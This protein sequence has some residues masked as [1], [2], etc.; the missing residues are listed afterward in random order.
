MVKGKMGLP[1]NRVRWLS[2]EQI[3]KYW[4]DEVGCDPKIIQQELQLAL[5]NLPRLAAGEQLLK[6]HPP[7][8]HLPAV[9]TPFSR[10]DILRFC[11]KQG[12]PI[13]EFWFGRPIRE[14]GYAGRPAKRK[15]AIVQ[16]LERL[17]AAGQLRDTLADQARDL[18]EWAADQFPHDEVATA[19]TIE[20]NIRERYHLLRGPPILI[21]ALLSRRAADI[22]LGIF[23]IG[24]RFSVVVKQ[25]V[26][27][28]VIG[29][30]P[31]G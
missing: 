17:A 13:P 16:E 26:S 6:E 28:I 9:E 1:L 27:R 15:R 14:K 12:W 30:V 5:L 7:H 21:S 3:A 25:Y 20:N 4:G 8:E 29:K 10:E 19:R 31:Q 24:D 2:I 11:D 23:P 18:S 22:W